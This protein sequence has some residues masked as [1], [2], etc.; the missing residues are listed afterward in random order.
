MNGVGV[1]NKQ[2]AHTLTVLS[3][4]TFSGS[5][6]VADGQ[7]QVGNG[8]TSGSLGSLTTTVD[9]GASLAFNR[10]ISPISASPLAFSIQ[11]RRPSIQRRASVPLSRLRKLILASG[12]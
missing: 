4:F 10:T 3:N 6:Q 8:G 9:A 12:E 1:F 5:V 2:G 11:L 7:L